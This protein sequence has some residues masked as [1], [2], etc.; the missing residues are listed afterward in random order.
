MQTNVSS[1]TKGQ[2][3]ELHPGTDAWMRGD[4]FGV[5]VRVGQRHPHYVHVHMDRSGLVRRIPDWA[6]TAV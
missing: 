2:R 4:R 6:L 3:V 1:F 5:V